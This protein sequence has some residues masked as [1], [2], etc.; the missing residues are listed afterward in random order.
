MRRRDFARM[1]RFNAKKQQNHLSEMQEKIYKDGGEILD[2][3]VDKAM[4]STAPKDD[5][6]MAAEPKDDASYRVVNHAHQRR[7]DKK[8]S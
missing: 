2:Y 5:A 6:V 3:R 4:A 1:A 8:W 7:P